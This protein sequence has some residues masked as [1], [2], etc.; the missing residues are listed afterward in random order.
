MPSLAYHS[1]SGFVCSRFGSMGFIQKDIQS[2]FMLALQS[3]M[4]DELLAGNER[5]LH[6]KVTVDKLF[7]EICVFKPGNVERNC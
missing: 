3:Y 1:F 7:L 5:L 6:K 2:F 4:P